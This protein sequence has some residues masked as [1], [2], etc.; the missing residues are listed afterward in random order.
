[1]DTEQTVNLAARLPKD[2][3]RK[4]KKQ[5]ERNVRSLNSELIVA[6]RYYLT[7]A[8]PT[9]AQPAEQPEEGKAQ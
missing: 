4:L 9:A 6:V 2:L 5:A 1:M 7:G 8:A 3:H